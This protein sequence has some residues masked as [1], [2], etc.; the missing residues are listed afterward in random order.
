MCVRDGTEKCCDP[1]N[2]EP[3]GWCVLVKCPQALQQIKRKSQ[4]AN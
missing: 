3:C 2:F 4:G 1:E